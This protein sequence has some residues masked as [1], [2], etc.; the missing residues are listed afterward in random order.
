MSA[1][2]FKASWYAYSFQYGKS[3]VFIIVLPPTPRLITSNLVSSLSISISYEGYDLVLGSEEHDPSV[4]ESPTVIILV[5]P[6]FL[7]SNA[8]RVVFNNW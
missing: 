1:S 5:T 7:G 2:E 8:G 3:P 4:I 6:S